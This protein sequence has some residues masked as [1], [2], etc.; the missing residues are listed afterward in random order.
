MGTTEAIVTPSASQLTSARSAS[1]R[2]A[3]TAAAP[4]R[5]QRISAAR[6]PTWKNGIASHQRSPGV[7]AIASPTASAPATSARPDS[8]AAFGTPLVPEVSKI[9][10]GALTFGVPGNAAPDGPSAKS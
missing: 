2:P 9:A 8:T 5:A 10:I 3:T 7:R 4:K 6:P 1:K